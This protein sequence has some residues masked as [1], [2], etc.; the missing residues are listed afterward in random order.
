MRYAKGH[1]AK[2]R[3]RILEAAAPLFRQR[4]V[5]DVSV[6]ELMQAAGLTRGGFYAHFDSKDDL[7]AEILARDAGLVR[8]MKDR[9]GPS[10]DEL[11]NQALRILSDY[12][13]PENIDEIASSCPLVSMPIDAA[14]GS[15]SLRRSYARRFDELIR[16]LKRGLGR[17]RGNESRAIAAAVLAAGGVLFAR[18]C[19]DP[20]R[21]AEI[22]RACR[23][24]VTRLLE[25][26][27]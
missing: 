24:Q 10:A 20:E 9:P 26:R 22:E 19:D 3:E 21:A 27:G 25:D 12:M 14:R 7:V 4:G 23:E 2:T 6:D 16:Q 8:L 15:Q 18:A 13:A 17:G 1:K 5:D 11:N